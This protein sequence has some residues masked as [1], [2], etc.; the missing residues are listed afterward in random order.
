MQLLSRSRHSAGF[1]LIELMIVVAV[2]AILAAIAYASYSHF[3]VKTRRNAATVC[4]QASAQYMERYY[5]TNMTYEDATDPATCDEVSDFYT[6]SFSG[7]PDATT[8]VIQAVPQGAQATADT[9]CGTLTINQAGTRTA[10]LASDASE[11]W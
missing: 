5:T 6:L 4:L 2:V 1:T 8:F 7:T 11:C 3:V 9:S 10:S